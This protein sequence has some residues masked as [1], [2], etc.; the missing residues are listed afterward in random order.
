MTNRITVYV[1]GEQLENGGFQVACYNYR[2]PAEKLRIIND[3]I[4][5]YYESGIEVIVEVK[6]GTRITDWTMGSDG[7]PD[8]L[9]DTAW[10]YTR[11]NFG[12]E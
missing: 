1:N 5:T 7:Q 8:V 6:N 9:Y 4:A 2:S 12:C 11:E 3:A 10:S